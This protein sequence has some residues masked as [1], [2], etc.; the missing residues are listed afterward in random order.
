MNTNPLEHWKK[1]IV[2]RQGG[3]AVLER[4]GFAGRVYYDVGYTDDDGPYNPESFE[5]LISNL[6]RLTI[7][8]QVAKELMTAFESGLWW[9]TTHANADSSKH[10]LGGMQVHQRLQSFKIV[11]RGKEGVS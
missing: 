3:W 10:A 11:A 2:Y 8:Q 4:L 5:T 9:A 1:R 7:A 6:G